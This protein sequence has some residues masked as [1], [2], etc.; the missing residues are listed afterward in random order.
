MTHTDTLKDQLAYV[1]GSFKKQLN[2]YDR[3]QVDSY[4]ESLISA[5][6]AACDEFTAKCVEYDGLF[7]SFK[8]LEAHRHEEPGAGVQI[9][10]LL[11]AEVLARNIIEDAYDDAR[12]IVNDARD[13]ARK[14]AGE[15]R[16]DAQTIVEEA[17]DVIERLIVEMQ[18][19]LTPRGVRYAMQPNL[20]VLA[21]FGATKTG[22]QKLIELSGLDFTVRA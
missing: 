17:G 22:T 7:E 18:R 15:A 16:E 11:D 21:P 5:Y 20:S 1:S 19:L 12:R 4:I 3:A 2:G 6:W 10:T 9:T 14:I 13:D 8:E